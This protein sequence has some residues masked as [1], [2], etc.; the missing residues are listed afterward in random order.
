MEGIDPVRTS[1]LQAKVPEEALQH[2]DELLG[3]L[4]EAVAGVDALDEA[5]GPQEESWETADAAAELDE[6]VE[7]QEETREAVAAAAELDEGVEDAVLEDAAREHP[8]RDREVWEGVEVCP[9]EEEREEP[10]LQRLQ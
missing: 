9:E 1:P 5:V 3:A 6:A 2:D 7:P 10:R 8:G 4:L